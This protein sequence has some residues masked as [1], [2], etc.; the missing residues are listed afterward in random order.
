MNFYNIYFV[1]ST[2]GVI[3]YFYSL[4]L[5]YMSRLANNA[6]L[7]VREQRKIRKIKCTTKPLN[8]MAILD[9]SPICLFY[10]P[11]KLYDPYRSLGYSP[12]QSSIS[13]TRAFQELYSGKST[14]IFVMFLLMYF[15]TP[16]LLCDTG[17]HLYL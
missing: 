9:I 6:L 10:F 14:S 12:E 17:P 4:T 5:P 1:I 8:Q 2:W 11:I 15:T 16:M 3:N 7:V 13:S